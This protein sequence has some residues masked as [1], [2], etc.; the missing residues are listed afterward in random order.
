MWL[1]Q[2]LTI[3]PFVRGVFWCITPATV[4]WSC[5]LH[6]PPYGG[7]VHYTSHQMVLVHLVRLWFSHHNGYNPLLTLNKEM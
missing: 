5:A 2:P 3:R 7:A 6:Q 4:W 1:V